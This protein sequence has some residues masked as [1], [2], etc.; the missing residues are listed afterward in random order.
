MMTNLVLYRTAFWQV[1]ENFILYS[2]VQHPQD[3]KK[4]YATVRIHS[5]YRD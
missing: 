4:W 2:D 5:A 3:I 1:R